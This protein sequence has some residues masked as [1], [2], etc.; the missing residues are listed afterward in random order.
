M[1]VH[2]KDTYV[3]TWNERLEWWV[4][5]AVRMKIV[6]AI[7]NVNSYKQLYF[8]LLKRANKYSAEAMAIAV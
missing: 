8:V 1:K 6:C 3:P 7:I 4:M 5:T 2:E